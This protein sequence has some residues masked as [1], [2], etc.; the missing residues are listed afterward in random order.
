M[1]TDEGPSPKLALRECGGRRKYRKLAAN[2]IWTQPL[3]WP[4]DDLIFVESKNLSSRW[5]PY[6]YIYI[7]IMYIYIHIYLHICYIYVYYIY[8]FTH[9]YYRRWNCALANHLREV[10]DAFCPLYVSIYKYILH[11]IN[12]YYIY[13][14]SLIYVL[15]ICI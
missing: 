15:H 7:Y 10:A 11:I 13:V 6:I 5:M 8:I 4:C 1:A 12:M 2:V 3:Q 9:M 14:L